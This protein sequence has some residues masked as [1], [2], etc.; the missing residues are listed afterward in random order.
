[1]QWIEI[2]SV[3]SIIH[4]LSNWDQHCIPSN[5]TFPN[6]FSYKFRKRENGTR[7]AKKGRMTQ[8]RHFAFYECLDLESWHLASRTKGCELQRLGDF[9][10]VW[11]KWYRRLYFVLD[12]TVIKQQDLPVVPF[13]IW[14]VSPEKMN[15]PTSFKTEGAFDKDSMSKW[16][17]NNC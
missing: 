7:K 17:K 10:F 16:V 9:S 15:L 8:P 11:A 4:P 6:K 2:Y 12:K 3:D 14:N 1:M 5:P 13:F